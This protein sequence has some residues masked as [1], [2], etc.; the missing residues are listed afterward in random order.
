MAGHLREGDDQLAG[1]G[2]QVNMPDAGLLGRELVAIGIGD[3]GVAVAGPA[4][5][6]APEVGRHRLLAVRAD[7]VDRRRDRALAPRVDI[8]DVADEGIVVAIVPDDLADGARQPL[9]HAALLPA[10]GA[11]LA[12]LDPAVVVLQIDHAD[13]DH[14]VGSGRAVLEVHLHA[15][16]VAAGRIELQLVVVAEPVVL[17]SG[18]DCADGR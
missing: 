6:D 14:V 8:Q 2:R 9:Q 11:A 12:Q 13:L 18:G 4:V 7:R 16:D 5:V 10:P 15:Q 1:A 3:A 17:R